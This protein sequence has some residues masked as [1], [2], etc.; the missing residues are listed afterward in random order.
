MQ[1]LD[2]SDLT[3]RHSLWSSSGLV[4]ACH[5]DKQSAVAV[6][7]Y[8]NGKV[9]VWNIPTGSLIN[10]YTGQM[11]TAVKSVCVSDGLV[12]AAYVQKTDVQVWRW[13]RASTLCAS[14]VQMASSKLSN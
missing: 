14:S 9:A 7:G 10:D 4:T 1:V 6:T 11:S 3:V 12:V 8:D 5:V 13:C 2:V